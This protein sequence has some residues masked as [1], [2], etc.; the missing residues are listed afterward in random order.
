MDKTGRVRHP[1]HSGEMKFN[2]GSM[3]Q[4]QLVGIDL[5]YAEDLRAVGTSA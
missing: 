4:G 3:T 1:S 2:D 5:D